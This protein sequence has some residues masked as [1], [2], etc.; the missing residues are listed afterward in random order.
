M[1]MAVSVPSGAAILRVVVAGGFIGAG[2]ALQ[3]WQRGR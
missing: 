3:L 1:E 2:D